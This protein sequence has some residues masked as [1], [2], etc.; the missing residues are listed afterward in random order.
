MVLALVA[1]VILVF[2]ILFSG[3]AGAQAMLGMTLSTHLLGVL[4]LDMA[5]IHLTADGTHLGVITMGTFGAI[6]RITT[7]IMVATTVIMATGIAILGTMAPLIT[8]KS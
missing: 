4:R 3:I 7:T 2:T 6:R 5:G 1:G 8:S